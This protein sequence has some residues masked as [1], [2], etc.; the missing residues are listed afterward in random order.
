MVSARLPAT[1]TNRATAPYWAVLKKPGDPSLLGYGN[2]QNL[3]QQIGLHHRDEADQA[4]GD[5]AIG[6]GGG[7]GGA[8]RFV[9]LITPMY[10]I[11]VQVL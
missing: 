10:S 5:E 6:D 2:V 4:R 11:P 9:L 7:G 3:G 1:T 8:Y